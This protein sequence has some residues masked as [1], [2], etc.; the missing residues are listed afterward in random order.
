[1]VAPI[2]FASI[3]MDAWSAKCML[4]YLYLNLKENTVKIKHKKSN[5]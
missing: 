5:V 4:T 1:M 2:I 3:L